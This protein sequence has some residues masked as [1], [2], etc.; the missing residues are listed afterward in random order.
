MIE[1]SETNLE[2]RTMEAY[3]EIYEVDLNNITF[4]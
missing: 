4:S 3:M 1:K 2:F